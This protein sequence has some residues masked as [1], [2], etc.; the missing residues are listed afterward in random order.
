MGIKVS[1]RFLCSG[2]LLENAHKVVGPTA[3]DL[4]AIVALA[5]IMRYYG[6]WI[7]MKSIRMMACKCVAGMAS[8]EH[9]H[10]SGAQLQEFS[11]AFCTHQD[12][13]G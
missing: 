2:R 1:R 10:G 7:L 8:P 6:W 11:L 9:A 3:G 13:E 12:T 4:A 5:V